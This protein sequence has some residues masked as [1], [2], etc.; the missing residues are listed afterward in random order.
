VAEKKKN[1]KVCPICDGEQWLY[2]D[3]GVEMVPR[4]CKCLKRK[5]LLEHLGPEIFK[6]KLIRSELLTNDVD[7][8]EDNLF[9]KGTWEEV[10]RHL[11]WVL[12]AKFWHWPGFT[13][14]I[15]DD[16][17]LLR[18][19]LGAEKYAQR[20]KEVRDSVQSYNSLLDLVVDST[21]TIIRIGQVSRNRAIP[22]VLLETL[23]AREVRFKPTWIVEGVDPFNHLHPAYSDAVAEYIESRYDIVD[24]GGDKEAER[25]AAKE[26]KEATA[27]ELKDAVEM[28]IAMGVNIQTPA[29]HEEDGTF[30]VPGAERRPPWKKRRNGGSGSGGLSDLE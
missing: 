7:R 15:L 27:F 2:R 8:T 16:N 26:R 17:R 24:L 22:D 12:S 21:L 10:C 29:Y 9:I 18:V 5:M 4:P 25:E 13:H 11:L 23:R 28:G 30:E 6:A 1:E 14:Q 19:W 20:S 3:D